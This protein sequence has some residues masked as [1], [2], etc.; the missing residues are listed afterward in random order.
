VLLRSLCGMSSGLRRRRPA[1]TE[2]SASPAADVAWLIAVGKLIPADRSR[3]TASMRSM[4]PR[5]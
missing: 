1:K 5:L 3:M 4:S 2:G